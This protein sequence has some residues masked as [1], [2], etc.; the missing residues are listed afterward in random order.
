[1]VKG[2]KAVREDREIKRILDRLEKSRGSAEDVR[3][4]LAEVL[5]VIGYE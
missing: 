3:R 1:M 2:P 5:K 4:T